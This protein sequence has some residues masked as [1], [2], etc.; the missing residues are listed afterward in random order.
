M[1][2]I[3]SLAAITALVIVGACQSTADQGE[4]DRPI[5]FNEVSSSY[6]G[7][8]FSGDTLEDAI[9]T[10]RDGDC[11]V[12]KTNLNI[13]DIEGMDFAQIIFS[14]SGR[15][16]YC[17]ITLVREVDFET[18]QAFAYQWSEIRPGDPPNA[19]RQEVSG[20]L[21]HGND[22]YGPG[23]TC[24]DFM[25][26]LPKDESITVHRLIALGSD[27]WGELES[28]LVGQS[29]FWRG[30]ARCLTPLEA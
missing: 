9:L 25:Y 5:G 8:E 2:Q 28:R 10:K 23:T 12:A 21:R 22:C 3:T 11:Y 13:D 17:N 20:T 29:D 1:P 19:V 24:Y 6:G 30:P 18:G 15:D 7:V 27:C 16:Q 14:I 4:T 26:P